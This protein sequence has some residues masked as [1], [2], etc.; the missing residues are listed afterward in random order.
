MVAF[1]VIFC[2]IGLS[3]LTILFLLRAVSNH[4][5]QL[6]ILQNKR[7]TEDDAVRL[8][9]AERRR[10]QLELG[11]TTEHDDKAHCGDSFLVNDAMRRLQQDNGSVDGLVKAGALL[12]A[13]IDRR[14]R[15]NR[16]H[17]L[18]RAAHRVA[19]KAGGSVDVTADVTR[20]AMNVVD[21]QPRKPRFLYDQ[22][23]QRDLTP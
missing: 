10:Q 22:H 2:L 4:R 6:A 1:T 17:V 5:A 11:W 12:A 19:L 9:L 13:E 8:I 21:I 15:A 20:D 16:R 14:I 18:M 7:V 23:N 3:A